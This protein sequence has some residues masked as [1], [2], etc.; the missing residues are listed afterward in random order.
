MLVED[1]YRE[2]MEDNSD[3]VVD[4]FVDVMKAYKPDSGYTEDERFHLFN[5][6]VSGIFISGYLAHKNYSKYI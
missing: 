1:A 2:F 4:D 6:F 3:K 5:D